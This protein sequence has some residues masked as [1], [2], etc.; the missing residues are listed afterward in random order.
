M[1]FLVAT[2]QGH[3]HLISVGKFYTVR[4]RCLVYR[5]VTDDFVLIVDLRNKLLRFVDYTVMSVYEGCSLL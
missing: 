4:G 5:D 2:A 3:I 1:R